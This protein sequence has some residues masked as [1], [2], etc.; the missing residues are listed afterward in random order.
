[1][2]I[3]VMFFGADDGDSRSHAA[4]YEDILAIARAAD[5][6]GFTAVW[7]PERHFQNFGQ[8]FPSPAVLGAALAVATERIAVRAGSVVLPLHHPLRVVE[9]WAVVD[10]LS[11]GRVGVSIATGW[12]STDFVLAP[13]KYADRREH[14]MSGIPLLR[15]LWAGE[16]VTLPDGTGTQAEVR[17]Q[18]R[19]VSPCLPIWVTASG[20]PDTWVA[21]GRLRANVLS[22]TGGQS[23]AELAEKIRCYRQAYATAPEQDGTAGDGTVTLMAHT[24]VG[25]DDDSVLRRVAAPLR[26]YLRSYVAQTATNREAASHGGTLTTTDT[27]L[28]TEFALRRY[29]AWGSLLGSAA[30]CAKSLADL[31]DLGCDEVACFVD[32]GLD[33]EE[34]LASLYRLADVQKGLAT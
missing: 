6:L 1:M 9:D 33:R 27:D 3:S 18:P 5:T 12:H 26:G 32:F 4:K 25:A 20:R 31:R 17:P 28:L 23:R 24:Y 29:L 11:G 8:V 13:G 15:R 21:A 16:A 7:T 19:P 30:T 22:A 2:D 10:N 14:A 34:V